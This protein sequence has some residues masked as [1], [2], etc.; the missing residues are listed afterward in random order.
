MNNNNN[1]LNQGINYGYNVNH[2]NLQGL[3]PAVQNLNQTIA[4]NQPIQLTYQQII[5]AK[6]NIN[7][8]KQRINAVYTM[9]NNIIPDE[10]LGGSHR[11]SS[12]KK[13]STTKSR[14]TKTKS[15]SRKN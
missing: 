8:A 3:N 11:R 14:K 6:N 4:I 7:I 9:L 2:P 12:I 15:K 10:H 1:P 5:T 13:K